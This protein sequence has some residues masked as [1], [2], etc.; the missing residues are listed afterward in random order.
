MLPL[1]PW[2]R[3]AIVAALALLLFGAGWLVRGWRADAAIA[4]L[5]ATQANALQKLA[6]SNND[7]AQKAADRQVKLQAAAAQ[8]D[9]L[10]GEL[11]HAQADIDRLR[12]AVAAGSQRVLIRA[13]CPAA[14]SQVPAATAA[15]SVGHATTVELA[16]IVGTDILG[17]KAGIV[18]DQSAL[19]A[20][21]TYV[22]TVCLAPQ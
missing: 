17:I 13:A 21:Q 22:R 1:P 18:A 7:A 6:E 16:P 12:A 3:T 2:T 11:T 5:R 9:S 8:V 10:Q 20:L 15:S 4:E 14:G 19:T